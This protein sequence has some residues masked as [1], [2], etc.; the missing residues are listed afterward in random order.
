M[1]FRFYLPHLTG[2]PHHFLEQDPFAAGDF[3][4]VPGHQAPSGDVCTPGAGEDL[5]HQDTA[6]AEETRHEGAAEHP[7][8]Q[9]FD[10]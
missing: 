2:L 1:R 5:Y 8:D 4:G 9:L 3:E 7:G 6:Q 10:P